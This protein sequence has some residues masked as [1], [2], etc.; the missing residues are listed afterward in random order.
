MNW[1]T[2][3]ANAGISEAPGYQEA[4][5]NMRDY[6]KEK[7]EKKPAPKKPATK[8]STKKK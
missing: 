1:T 4:L 2:I 7:T 6:P 5:Q 3:L 8:K